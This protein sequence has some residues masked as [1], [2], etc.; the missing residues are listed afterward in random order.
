MNIKIGKVI[1]HIKQKKI[2]KSI[3]NK[4]ITQE[5]LQTL[6][7]SIKALQE[8]YADVELAITDAF[9][10]LIKYCKTNYSIH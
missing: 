10:T 3:N 4:K 8:P 1:E 2:G 7:V 6:S 9:K 5:D